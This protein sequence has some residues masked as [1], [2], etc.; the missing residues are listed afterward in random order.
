MMETIA[1]IFEGILQDATL[2]V[3]MVIVLLIILL[4]ILIL[5]NKSFEKDKKNLILSTVLWTGLSIVISVFLLKG[6]SDFENFTNNNFWFLMTAGVGFYLL[7]TAFAVSEFY[8]FAA[9]YQDQKNRLTEPY[10]DRLGKVTSHLALGSVAFILFLSAIAFL[11]VLLFGLYVLFFDGTDFLI[12]G[13]SDFNFNSYIGFITS[14]AILFYVLFVGIILTR[15]N[16]QMKM[17]AE[18]ISKTADQLDYQRSDLRIKNISDKLR[19]TK[20]QI[21]DYY[22]PILNLFSSFRTN[23][24]DAA[25]AVLISDD[26]EMKRVLDNKWNKLGAIT[27][28]IMLCYSTYNYGDASVV[29]NFESD[30]FNSGL[31][32]MSRLDAERNQLIQDE[33]KL[34]YIKQTIEDVIGTMNEKIDY[35]QNSVLGEIKEKGIQVNQLRSER[36]QLITEKYSSDENDS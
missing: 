19:D 35:Y 21:E 13:F 27:D 4:S 30:V 3:T 20:D 23:F 33:E 25:H 28:E 9:Y 34:E 12:D 10:L 7:A 5:M 6:I 32:E 26:K 29:R 1:E 2:F 14:I 17:Q 31:D 15:L 36:D 24:N 8:K 22:V 16:D 18:N 11:F